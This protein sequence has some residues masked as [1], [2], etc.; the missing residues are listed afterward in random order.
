MF[1]VAFSVA[2][3]EALVVAE[4]PASSTADAPVFGALKVTT[5]LDRA[6]ESTSNTCTCRGVE[7]VWPIGVDC[8]APETTSMRWGGP[9]G[10]MRNTSPLA[11]VVPLDALVVGLVSPAEPEV[12]TPPTERMVSVSINVADNACMASAPL[13]PR[14]PEYTKLPGVASAILLRKP[15]CCPGRAVAMPLWATTGK[16]VPVLVDPVA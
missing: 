10:S 2:I 3:P 9:K 14:K 12:V 1:A 7:K 13:V 16:P 15:S 11:A 5:M 8:V 6:R 4:P